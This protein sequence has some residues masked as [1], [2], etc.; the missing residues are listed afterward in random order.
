MYF[1]RICVLLLT[2]TMAKYT[3]VQCKMPCVFVTGVQDTPSSKRANQQFMV[4]ASDKLNPEVTPLDIDS[5]LATEK[6][7]GTCCLVQEYQG[8]KC[9]R[10]CVCVCSYVCTWLQVCVCALV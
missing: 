6:V 4:T 1:V 9:V 3:A 2:E 10:T 7:D 5:A 8:S